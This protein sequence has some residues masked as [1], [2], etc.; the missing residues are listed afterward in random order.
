MRILFLAGR[1]L[2]YSRNDVVVR[3]LRR[4]GTVEAIGP[5]QAGSVSL[6]SLRTFLKAWP[7]LLTQRYEFIFVGFYGHFLMLPVSVLARAP[8]VF[9]AFLST[10]DTLCL[11]RQTYAPTSVPGRLA[12]WLDQSTARRAR[13]VLLDTPQHIDFFHQTFGVSREKF[14]ALPVGCNEDVFFPRPQTSGDNTT[15]VLY[16]TT[17]LPLHGAE[18]VVRAAAQLRGEA[19]LQFTL[20]GDGPEYVRVRRLAEHLQVDNVTFVRPVPVDQLPQHIAQAA[21]CLGG[22]FG[23]N[24]KAARVIPGKVYQILAMARPMVAADSPANRRLLTPGLTAE[25]CS[26]GDPQALAEAILQLKRDPDRRRHLAQ[27]GRA[28]FTEQC[29]ER[30]I[31]HELGRLI[32]QL[33]PAV[34]P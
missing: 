29:S 11:D 32:Q 1:E 31:T 18:V 15:R 5:R 26:A 4:L 6:N 16:Y 22:H 12:F 2:S 7:R 9:D 21:V 19:G 20:L 25:L 13:R 10:Y 27:A 33:T 17:F 14:V 28:L 30:V 24:G 3:A 23:T 8:V 34:T